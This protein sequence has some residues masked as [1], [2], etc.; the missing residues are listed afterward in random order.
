MFHNHKKKTSRYDALQRK[1]TTNTKVYHKVVAAK[2][3]LHHSV[4]SSEVGHSEM[5][6]NSDL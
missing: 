1:H 2:V 3:S 5:L 6:Q 4:D